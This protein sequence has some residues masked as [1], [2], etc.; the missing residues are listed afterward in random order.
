MGELAPALG[1]MAPSITR[2]MGE[3]ILGH[4]P[5]RAGSVPHLRGQ[6][7]WPSPTSS[8][9]TKTQILGLWLAHPNIFLICDLLE[10]VKDLVLRNSNYSISMAHGNST[11]T[12]GVRVQ[13]P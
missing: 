9:T 10:F 8:A 5:R 11:R 13:W 6:S 2:G 4:W 3:L 1:E 7:Q 12:R